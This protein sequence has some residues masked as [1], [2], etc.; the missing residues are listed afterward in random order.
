MSRDEKSQR[1]ADQLREL[2]DAQREGNIQTREPNVKS[3]Y[4]SKINPDFRVNEHEYEGYVHIFARKKHV[5]LATKEITNEDRVIKVHAAQFER[6]NAEGAFTV[7]DEVEIVHDPRKEKTALKKVVDRVDPTQTKTLGVKEAAE[8]EKAATENLQNFKGKGKAM[9]LKPKAEAEK[10][11][12]LDPNKTDASK[13]AGN[14]AANG[15]GPVDKTEG[16]E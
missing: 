11:A 14:D 4:L 13:G 6:R 10:E 3:N 5:Q 16:A 1:Q 12:G 9:P 7:Y 15:Q 8:A 2:Q